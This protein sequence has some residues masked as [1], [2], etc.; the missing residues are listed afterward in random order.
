MKRWWVLG[1]AVVMLVSA[2]SALGWAAKKYEGETMQVYAGMWPESREFIVEYIAPV[3]KEKWG[4]DLAVEEMGSKAMLEK[5]V[6]TRDSPTVTICGWDMSIAVIATNMGLTAPI[7]VDL[8][9]NVKDLY[10]WGVH[11]IN[12]DIY[13][14][15]PTLCGIGF[16]YNSEVFER[17]GL[18]PPTGWE[19]LW[20][21]D[22]K[23]RVSITSPESGVGTL[24]LLALSGWQ[25]AEPYD[26]MPG[27]EKLK[28]L[29]PNLH[30]IHLWSSELVKLLQ[31]NEVWL[32]P[33]MSTLVPSLKEEGFSI[34]WGGMSQGVPMMNGGMSIIKNAPYQDVAHDFINLF[35][36]VEYQLRRVLRA[37]DTSANKRVYTVLSGAELAKMPIKP[38]E[39]DDLI[40]Y[41]WTIIDEHRAEWIE[42]Y[43]REL[44]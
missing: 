41:D 37:G 28:T 30:S 27:I 12:G 29:L 17:E 8:A 35:F 44:E 5:M 26:I 7:N 2:L 11:K 43:H 10:D 31:L 42:I 9:P 34:A 22:L 16:L 36:S 6:I 13:A 38:E 15:A 1:L 23:D 21:E 3:L 25:G 24:Q 19:D 40:D 39:F 33:S 4:I 18:D 20:R 32:A 14:L